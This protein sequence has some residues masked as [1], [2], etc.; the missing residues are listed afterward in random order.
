MKDEIG[1]RIP[2]PY[3]VYIDENGDAIAL[4]AHG[5]GP[6]GGW[7][8]V[9]IASVDV[10]SKNKTR[11]QINATA[12]HFVL[13]ANTHDDLVA[14]AKRVLYKLEHETASVDILDQEALAA[15]IARATS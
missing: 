8:G 12:A 6:Q 1:S 15:A 11:E 9:N 14:A 10:P 7:Q 5:K 4:A 2:G 13:S 3:Y